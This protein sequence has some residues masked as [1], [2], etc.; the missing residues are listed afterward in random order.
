MLNIAVFRDGPFLP[1][2]EGGSESLLGLME[3]MSKHANVFLFRCNRGW[4]DYKLY[5]KKRF[6][7]IFI[8][9]E[10]YYSD[11]NLYNQLL[12]KFKID[13]CHFDSAEAVC[14]Q[15]HLI[16]DDILK[17]WDVLNVNHTLLARTGKNSEL[18]N[19]AKK[20]EISAASLSDLILCRSLKDTN[21][22]IDIGIDKLKIRR[23][24]GCINPSNFLFNPNQTN[25]KN[26]LFLGNMFYE[27]NENAVKL[28]Q[29]KIIPVVLEQSP[30]SK[31]IFTGNF[32]PYLKE[33]T[34]S[35]GEKVQFTGGVDDL[36]PILSTVKVALCPLFE[37]S[38]TRLKLLTYLSA[39]VPTITTNLGI[40]GLNQ[41]ISTH[42]IVE[43]KI[44]NYPNLILKVLSQP[45]SK[46]KLKK[47]RKWIENNY[48]WDIESK[49]ILNHYENAISD[50]NSA[51][52]SEVKVLLKS[53]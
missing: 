35:Y 45:Y 21:D 53:L 17:V 34:Q 38:G 41:D 7:T 5:Q 9:P 31:F 8:R 36:N 52:E 47:A 10:D 6:N 15:T 44:E 30:T 24:K 49:N 18:V 23:Y 33:R 1:P 22:L 51:N 50:K 39:G 42:L 25:Q 19:N 40:E 13:V 26:I 16:N 3:G 20:Y 37:G 43:D 2:M 27:P 11:K 12:T 4:D 46:E 48:S 29:D 14:L 32:P 28:I